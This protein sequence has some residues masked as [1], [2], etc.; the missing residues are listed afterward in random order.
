MVG[1]VLRNHKIVRKDKNNYLLNEFE[2]LNPQEIQELIKVCDLKIEEYIEN[3]GK[4]IWE[5]R[6]RNRR[7]VPGSIRYEVLKRAEGRCELCGISK[8][9]KALEVDHIVPKNNGGEDSINNYQALCYSCNSSK[10]DKDDTD[11]RNLN[12][13]YEYR[14]DNCIFC[15]NLEQKIILEN[16][17]AYA[18][19]D[20]YAVTEF[21][22]LIIPKRHC[23]TYFDLTQAEINSINSLL[24]KLKGLLDSKDGSIKGYNIGINNG[25]SAGQTIMHCHIHLIPRRN[26]DVINPVG[27][28]RNVIDGKGDYMN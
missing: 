26:G 21:H 23:D 8:D 17:L 3:R 2:E 12:T 16:H 13:K 11:F 5:H 24:H 9:E 1:K 15:K 25:E 18:I 19:Y 28:V 22:S 4:L 6:R 14:S 20:K 7:A 10:R 27:G